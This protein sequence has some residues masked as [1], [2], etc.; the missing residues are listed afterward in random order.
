MERFEIR[1]ASRVHATQLAPRLRPCD[2]LEIHRASGQEPLEALLESI[3]VSDDDMCWTA[4][5]Q[6]HPVA[7]FGAN[8][9]NPDEPGVAGG[10]WLLASAGIYE[11]KLDF[12][13]CCKKY[14]AVMHERY[15]FLTNFIDK[16]NIPTQ[17]WLPRLGFKPCLEVAE[18]GAGKTPFIQYLSKRN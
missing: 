11:N 3:R 7:M 5:W 18:F 14:L 6:G 9:L 13:R 2:M 1:P 15:E 10:I 12:M 8:E 16:D 17:M 4:L